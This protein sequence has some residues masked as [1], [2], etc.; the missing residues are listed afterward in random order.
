MAVK[1][2]VSGLYSI[3]A[4]PVNAFRLDSPDGCA[5]ID[6]GIPGHAERILH[7]MVGLVRLPL[8]IFGISSLRMHIPTA[9]AAMPL[10]G[11]SL[12]RSLT[13]ILWTLRL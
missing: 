8:P 12:V 4:G 7:A 6:T 10:L 11:T 9:S 3:S 2:I 13:F 5:L 1:Q